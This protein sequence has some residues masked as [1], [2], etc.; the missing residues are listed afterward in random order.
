M[1]KLLALAPLSVALS[2]GVLGMT[3]ASDQQLATV[4]GQGW[5]NS[6]CVRYS[7]P[8]CSWTPPGGTTNCVSPLNPL[9][10]NPGAA[11]SPCYR[12]NVGPSTSDACWLSHLLEDS[13]STA[14]DGWCVT[15][16]EG[17]CRQDWD[18]YGNPMNCHCLFGDPITMGSRIYC[19]AGSTECA[20]TGTPP[21]HQP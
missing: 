6:C 2:A 9:L 3:P 8:M 13:C 17:T 19:T 16:Q 21:G 10:C 11:G 15:Y 20:G 1:Y 4:F 18:G 12:V 7:G 5:L 14:T